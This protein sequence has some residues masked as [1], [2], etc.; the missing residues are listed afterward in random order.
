VSVGARTKTGAAK[1][2]LDKPLWNW[3]TRQS[4]STGALLDDLRCSPSDSRFEVSS[5]EVSDALG[6]CDASP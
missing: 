1:V 5:L 6:F 3:Q 4:C 2:V